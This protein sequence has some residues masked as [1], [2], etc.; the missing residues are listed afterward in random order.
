MRHQYVP[1]PE[2]ASDRHMHSN[3]GVSLQS[4]SWPHEESQLHNFL[5]MLR[6]HCTE[7]CK[8]GSMQDPRVPI[9]LY[10]KLP[11]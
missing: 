1:L 3:H 11:P 10:I 4:N 8:E 5:L 6:L 2:F 7:G 9:N